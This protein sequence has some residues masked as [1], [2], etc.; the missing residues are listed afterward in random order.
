MIEAD[1]KLMKTL[2][3]IGYD[4]QFGAR[5]LKRIMQRRILNELSKEIIA[6]NI[7]K[8]SIIQISVDDFDRII[9]TNK[10][11]NNI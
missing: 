2:A 4:P 9:F 6:D 1:E 7:T 11:K 8:D 5:P 10:S 3:E